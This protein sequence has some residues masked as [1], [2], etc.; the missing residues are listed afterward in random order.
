MTQQKLTRQLLN[1][2]ATGTDGVEQ[3]DLVPPEGKGWRFHSVTI[4]DRGRGSFAYV[5]WQHEAHLLPSSVER[6]ATAR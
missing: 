1:M 2:T 6:P 5:V 4:E 3:A